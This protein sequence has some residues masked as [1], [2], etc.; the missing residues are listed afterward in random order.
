MDAC[1]S[2]VG[3]I[4]YMIPKRINID[5]DHR[6][7]DGYAGDIWSLGVSILEFYLGIFSFAVGREGDLG[8]LMRAICTLDPPKSLATP[9]RELR[10]FIPC[11]LHRDPTKRLVVGIL[12]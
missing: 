11:C 7:Y 3:T 12:L 4:A 1:N 6:K 5:L 10:D 9:S 2:F 8:N